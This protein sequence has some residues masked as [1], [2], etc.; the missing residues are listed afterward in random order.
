[1]GIIYSFVLLGFVLNAVKWINRELQD[2]VGSLTRK[3]NEIRSNIESSPAPQ[4]PKQ[5]GFLVRDF[6]SLASHI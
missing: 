5:R 2:A 4:R 3:V 6:T 1:M